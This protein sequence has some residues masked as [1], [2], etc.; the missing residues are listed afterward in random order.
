MLELYSYSIPFKKPFVT[1]AGTFNTR[2]GIILRYHDSQIDVVLEAAPL[3]GFSTE[4]LKQVKVELRA[5]KLEADRFFRLPFT[6][7]ELN[8]W[9]QNHTAFPSSAFGFSSLGLFILSARKSAPIAEMLSVQS[10]GSLRVNAVIGSSSEDDFIASAEKHI[11]NGFDVIKCK[12]TNDIGHLPESIKKIAET[13]PNVS[14]RLDANRSWKRENLAKLSSHFAA[15]PIEYIEEPCRVESIDQ[16]DSI[17]RDCELDVAL[18]ESLTDF[19]LIAV[20]EKIEA[21]PYLIVKPMFHGNLMEL[22][23]TIS[24]RFNLENRVIIT[25]ALESAIGTCIVAQVAAIIGS[26]SSAHGLN[27]DSL[28]RQNLVESFGITHGTIQ[29]DENFN[30]RFSF[31]DINQNLIKPL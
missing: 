18:D 9:I 10:A 26:R 17:I 14:F 20:L 25:T 13:F 23:A 21:S 12:V 22:F 7:Q 6:P 5:L 31:Q 16:L 2:E 30:D 8:Q 4:S 11:R 1:G 29:L 19:G 27:T 24:D 15:L 28:F 3:P